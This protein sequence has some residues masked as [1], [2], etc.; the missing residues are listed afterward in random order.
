MFNLGNTCF[1]SAIL[2][3]LVHCIPLQKYFLNECG[4]HHL[5]CQVYRDKAAAIA[6][7]KK[8]N[9]E[10]SKG[11]KADTPNS[12][13]TPSGE[14]LFSICLA[15]EMDRLFLMYYGSFL[16]KDV[17]GAITDGS[18]SLLAQRDLDP[19]E[20]IVEEKEV[21]KGDPLI[22]SDLLTAA[23]KSGGM[24][25]L[26]G[27]EQRDAHEFFNSFLDLMGKHSRQHRQRVFA[28]INTAKPDNSLV[29]KSDDVEYGKR[30]LLLLNSMLSNLT[31]RFLEFLDVVKQLFEGTLRSVLVCE[32]CG[33]KRTLLEPFVNISL[34]LSEEVERLQAE[35]D[36]FGRDRIRISVETCL[37]H[38]TS[39]EKL[40]DGV[41]CSPCGKKTQTMKQHTFSKLPKVLCLHLKRFDAIRNRKIDEF[42]SYPARDLNMGPLLSHW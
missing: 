9:S 35:N 33:G 16:G 27:Y 28:S 26:A 31:S 30:I 5:S 32:E 11:A 39:P 36:S 23:W 17:I 38:F 4:H 24:D 3:C 25:Y 1:Q 15:C 41:H 7:K 18:Q 12:A 8:K 34:T 29:P 19:K 10:P 2:Q 20:M 22:L 6:S 21:L 42:V 13:T 37:L 40:V 14:Q